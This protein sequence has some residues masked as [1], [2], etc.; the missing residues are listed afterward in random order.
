MVVMLGGLGKTR[1][2]IRVGFLVEEKHGEEDLGFFQ[3]PGSLEDSLQ[4]GLG[5]GLCNWLAWV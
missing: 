3:K 2:E 4:L 5:D 1:L